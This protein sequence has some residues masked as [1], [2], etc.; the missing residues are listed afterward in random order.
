MVK[1]DKKAALNCGFVTYP[2]LS[3]LVTTN[4]FINRKQVV[5]EP[6]VFNHVFYLEMKS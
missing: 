6:R 4:T 2:Q 1:V 5:R 3:G